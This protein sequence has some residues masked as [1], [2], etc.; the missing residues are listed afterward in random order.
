MIR[1]TPD[2]GEKIHSARD[3]STTT[4]LEKSA[5]MRTVLLWLHKEKA[6]AIARRGHIIGAIP[7]RLVI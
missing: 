7:D 4:V 6:P 3:R 2:A 1:S 5:L